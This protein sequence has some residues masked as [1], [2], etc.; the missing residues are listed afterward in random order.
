MPLLG[1]WVRS[2]G[3]TANQWNTAHLGLHD[4]S[5][6]SIRPGYWR[7][8]LECRG[9]R[10]AGR[11]RALQRSQPSH[12]G[13]SPISCRRSQV[14]IML[15]ARRMRTSSR[16]QTTGL[17]TPTRSRCPRRL[18][19]RW[20]PQRRPA[21][22]RRGGRGGHLGAG[23]DWWRSTAVPPDRGSTGT[24]LRSR[25]FTTFFA[26]PLGV[27]GHDRAAQ[28]K[29]H[30]LNAIYDAESASVEEITMK[31]AVTLLCLPGR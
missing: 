27:R 15:P 5:L 18:R 26:A 17:T 11:C 2:N 9:R 25:Y 28:D 6:P 1:D 29:L 23:C 31:T 24:P 19:D 13:S 20:P 12:R 21:G 10:L 3:N 16:D 4:E 22:S 7:C 14:A 8:R 30:R